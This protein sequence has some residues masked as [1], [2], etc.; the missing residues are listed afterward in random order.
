MRCRSAPED[1]EFEVSAKGHLW[2]YADND[3]FFE[4]DT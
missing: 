3:A 2:L 4:H 1:G